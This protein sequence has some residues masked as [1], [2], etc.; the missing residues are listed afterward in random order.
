MP[1]QVSSPNRKKGSVGKMRHSIQVGVATDA[2]EQLGAT[3]NLKV[4]KKSIMTSRSSICFNTKHKRASNDNAD[5][6]EEYP[7][8]VVEGG[9][10]K[11]Q[12]GKSQEAVARF[13]PPLKRRHRNTRSVCDLVAVIT[14]ANFATEKKRNE[15]S[16]R[17]ELM[18]V[19]EEEKPPLETIK[20]IVPAN[21]KQAW[22][23]L[24]L[25]NRR[26]LTC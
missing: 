12:G 22:I 11:R 18:E 20:S 8:L 21:M 15:S 17:I 13:A 25:K 14:K 26:Q 6:Q 23:D 19:K 24:G 4:S 2:Q 5:L 10:T 16:S 3:L 9:V 7:N 1:L